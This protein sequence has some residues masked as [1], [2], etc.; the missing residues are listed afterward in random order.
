MQM[1]VG[2][3]LHRAQAQNYME[4]GGKTMPDEWID[5]DTGH[6]VIRLVRR[7]GET[8]GSFYFNNYCFVPRKASEGD[9]MVFSG[10]V[11]DKKMGNQ[12]FTVNLKTLQI[13]QLTNHAHI[14]GEMVCPTTH[15]AFYQSG[16]S[17]WA[18]NA[19]TG[20]KQVH[21]RVRSGI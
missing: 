19:I 7:P 14:A 8:N 6:K 9:L 5:K 2:L 12:L 15:D 10:S 13:K 17:V 18:V 11:P 1:L 21:L 16:D 3:G 20:K 4:T